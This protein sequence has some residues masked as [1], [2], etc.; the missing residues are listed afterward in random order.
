MDL[1]ALKAELVTDP[2]SLGYSAGGG[3]ADHKA[4]AERLNSLATGRT[5][6]RQVVATSE[7]LEAA[8]IAE[9]RALNA[10]DREMFKIILSVGTVRLDNTRVRVMLTDMF[11]PETTTRANVAALQSE[12][13]SRATELF[14]TQVGYWDVS[15]ARGLP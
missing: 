8:T 9:L 4:D 1:A 13:I 11:G 12:P 2:A 15:N 7:I 6:D 5:R 14:D 10:T 3:L